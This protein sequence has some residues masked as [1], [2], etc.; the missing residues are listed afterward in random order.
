MGEET[1]D[2]VAQDILMF[3]DYTQNNVNGWTSELEEGKE[4]WVMLI[5]KLKII[6]V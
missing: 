3:N 6:C 5:F 1:L 2:E 4:F